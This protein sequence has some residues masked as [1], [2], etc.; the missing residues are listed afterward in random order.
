MRTPFVL[1]FVRTLEMRALFVLCLIVTIVMHAFYVLCLIAK[2]VMLSFFVFCLIVTFRVRTLF[3]TK[4]SRTFQG[5][6]R[7]QFQFFKHSI[8]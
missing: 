3:G 5:H 1:C 4:N 8:L 7:A 6:S 2:L